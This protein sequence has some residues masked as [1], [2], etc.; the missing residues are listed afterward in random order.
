MI[1]TYGLD[2]INVV[3]DEQEYSLKEALE[4]N[5]IILNDILVK[6]YNEDISYDGT[7]IYRDTNEEKVANGNLTIIKCKTVY[8]D[9]INEDVYIGTNKM[10]KEDYFCYE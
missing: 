7:I 4:Q 1:Y 8:D 6:L 2:E 5:K 9:E 10:I 3:I